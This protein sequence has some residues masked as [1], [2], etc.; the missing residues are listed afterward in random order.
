[1][2]T[3]RE[4]VSRKDENREDDEFEAQY[5][6]AR[7]TFGFTPTQPIDSMVIR[8]RMFNMMRN[9]RLK[10]NER[11]GLL[12]D[13][14]LLADREGFDPWA[15]KAEPVRQQIPSTLSPEERQ[16][17]IS[18]INRPASKPVAAASQEEEDP[19]AMDLTP[20]ERLALLKKKRQQQGLS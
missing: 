13:Y 17:I 7:Q 18:R 8:S 20:M 6:K 4:Y 12:K 3:F 1:M 11:E 16:E 15:V 19:E 14:N 10:D 5:D 9:P 2:I